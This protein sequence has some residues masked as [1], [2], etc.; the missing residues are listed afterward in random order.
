[1]KIGAMRILLALVALLYS[2]N[3]TTERQI[4][5]PTDKTLPEFFGAPCSV[6]TDYENGKCIIFEVLQKSKRKNRHK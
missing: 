3:A 5:E 4:I 2:T 6:S 1:V